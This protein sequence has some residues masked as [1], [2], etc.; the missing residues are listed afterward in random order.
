MQIFIP[1]KYSSS[2][3][4]SL[5]ELNAHIKPM[6]SA[7]IHFEAWSNHSSCNNTT[8]LIYQEQMCLKR[9]HILL[10]KMG[11]FVIRMFG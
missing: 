7:K 6:G 9:L 4:N 3:P 5:C 2:H 11:I 8:C 10:S 1:I